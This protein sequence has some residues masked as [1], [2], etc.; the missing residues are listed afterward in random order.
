M[1]S[2]YLLLRVSF[3]AVLFLINT[4][5]LAQEGGKYAK[6]LVKA[7]AQYEEGNYVKANKTLNKFKTKVVKKYGAKN[8]YLPLYYIRRAKFNLAEGLL[9]DFENSIQQSISASASIYGETADR[10][11]ITLLKVGEILAHYGDYVRSEEYIRSAQKTLESAEKLNDNLKAKIDITLARVLIGRGFYN[12]ALKFLDD[13]LEYFRKRAVTKESYLDDKGKLQSRKLPEA[14]V[15]ERLNDY[16]TLLTL[17]ANV[18]R[19]KGSYNEANSAFGTAKRWINQNLGSGSLAYVTNQLDFGQF[20]LENGLRDFNSSDV[21]DERFDKTL[22]NL[23]KNHEESHYLAFEL[24]ELLLKQYLANDN[25]AKYRNLKVEYEKAIKRNFKSNSLYRINLAT[26]EFDSKLDKQRT[27]NLASEAT[28]QANSTAL[29]KYHKKRV[30]IIDVLYRLALQNNDYYSALANLEDIIEIKKELYGE[31]SPE[32]HLAQ[33]ELANYYVDYTDKIK[34]AETIFNK[35]YY[36]IIEPQIDTWHKDYVGIQNHLAKYYEIIDNYEKAIAAVNNAGR[37]AADKFDRTDPAYADVLDNQAQLYISLADYDKAEESINTAME[38]FNDKQNNDWVVEKLEA[39]STQAE[40]RVI[41][42]LFD[43]AE[44]IMKRSNKIIRK[45]DDLGNYNDLASTEGLVRIYIPLGQ[46]IKAKELITTTISDYEKQFGVNSR[47]LI[48]PLVYQGQ[49]ELLEGE[50]TQAE[51]TARRANQIATTIYGETSSKLAPTLELLAEVYTNIGDYQKA[52]TNAEKAV[53]IQESQFGRNHVDVARSL[54]QLALIRFY[55]G[56]NLRD[57]EKIMD[58]AKEIIASKL[59]NRTPAYA[60]I[61]TDL[62]KVYISDRR[63]DDAFNALTLAENIWLSRAGRRNNVK[64]AAIYSLIGDIY[65]LQRNYDN[66]EEQYEKSKKIYQ[67]KFSKTHPEYVKVL[68]KLSKVYYMEGDTKGS[69]KY[70]EEAL[71]NHIDYIQKFFPALSEREKAKF[72][73][74]IQPDFEFYS[75]LAF[76]IKDQDKRAVG[77]VYNNA[78]LTKAIL[79][80]SSIKIRERIANSTDE[81]LKQMYNDWLVK[82]EELTN[83]L[84]MSLS[85]LQENEIDPIS[86]TAEVE[87]IEKQL[88]QKSTIFSESVENNKIRWDQVQSQLG[89]NEVAVEM[90]RYRYFDHIFTDSVVYAAMYIKN[91]KEQ[92]NPEVVLMGNGQELEGKLFK[93]YRNS[94]IFKVPD[95]YSYASYWKPLRDVLGAYSTIYL[96]AD[97]VYNQ[98]NLEAIPTDDGKYV[99]DNSNIVLVSNT[100][101]IWTNK[102]RTREVQTEKRASMFG[103]PDFYLTA[104]A[105]SISS[106]PGTEVEVNELR[107]LLRTEGW[108]T[109]SF[110]EESA[111]EEQ[112]KKLDNPKVFHVA[113]H[114]FFTPAEKMKEEERLIQS[115]SSAAKNPLLRTGLLLTGAGDLLNETKYNYNAKNGILTAYEAMNL[116]LDQTELVVLSACETGL[117]E[118]AVGEGVYGLQRAFLVAGAKVLIMSM[119]KVDDEA[120]QKL[121]TKFYR[122]WQE[123]GKMRDSFV[124]AKKELRNE[125]QDPIYWGAFIMIGIE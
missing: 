41:Q 16:A 66:A 17:R 53:E 3:I 81:E 73:N 15:K 107:N 44:D 48:V 13:N 59:G 57:V 109:S 101:D 80:S 14:E 2:H 10:H 75:T 20:L 125:Y 36:G 94:I 96:S 120:T 68:S 50:Y 86:L 122:K 85:D 67:N 72:W 61:S 92:A 43:E 105:G 4:W 63:Y 35:S 33:I 116:N 21:K 38:I 31:D 78:L 121:M 45:S 58:E 23:K 93:F 74:T 84:S 71:A 82:K 22:N 106:L 79:L 70:I 103:N 11:A 26:I 97:G 102:T 7:D 39:M 62:A 18:F 29:P 91:K 54:E 110:T 117:G 12:E 52:Q 65:Y 69:R 49:I 55:K 95:R 56:D 32:Y 88:S 51:R 123:T 104:S 37:A 87:Q 76:N 113:T 115:E 60:D 111:S 19:R 46:F 1:K 30:Q 27:K 40:L 34:D 100:K 98:I 114:G 9:L 64:A 89:P 124:A 6:V 118:L 5:S 42:G 8:E 112:I 83:V 119:F 24:Y 108:T 90:V 77:D 47:R 99:I 25:K 28:T